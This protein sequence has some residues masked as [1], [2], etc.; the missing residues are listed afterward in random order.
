MN[1]LGW[2]Q[3]AK[4]LSQLITVILTI[5]GSATGG[6]AYIG[7][8]IYAFAEIQTT[9]VQQLRGVQGQIG[10]AKA[11]LEAQNGERDRALA[12]LKAEVVPRIADLERAVTTAQSNAAATKQ[13][14]D[15]MKGDL[16]DLKD[17]ARQNLRISASHDD[18]I[19]ATR[20]AV[21]PKGI[22][23]ARGE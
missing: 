11:A 22:D 16:G 19:K 7:G 4:A 20:R 5:I 18:D 13:L 2:S 23:P 10:E 15:D 9:I 14:V 17:L 8:K 6:A 1:P 3:N 12:V 21:A